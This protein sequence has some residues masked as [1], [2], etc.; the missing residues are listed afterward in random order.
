MKEETLDQA[1]ELV[2][3]LEKRGSKERS[4]DLLATAWMLMELVDYICEQE[5]LLRTDD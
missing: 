3:N 5:D 2:R 1:N 4:P